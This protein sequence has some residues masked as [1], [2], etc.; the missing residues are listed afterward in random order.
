MH[1]IRIGKIAGVHIY[2]EKIVVAS[3]RS[4]PGLVIIV[5]EVA[6]QASEDPLQGNFID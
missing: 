1:F 3:Q 4:S 2:Y 5:E 6:Y